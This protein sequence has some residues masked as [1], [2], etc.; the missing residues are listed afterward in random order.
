MALFLTESDVRS[1]LPMPVLIE[2]MA[3]ALAQYSKGGVVQP[4][5][6]V[7]QVQGPHA[8]MAA[9]PAAVADPPAL[10]AKLVTVYHGNHARGLPSHL[11]TIVLLDHATGALLAVMD[12]RYI[13][14]ART[15]AVSAVSVAH[16]AVPDA[17]V[18]AILGSGVQAR[19]HFEAIRTVRPL[20]DVRIWS[21]TAAHRDACASEL[22]KSSGLNVRAV[23]SAA[24]AVNGAQIIALTTASPTPVLDL[25]DVTPG[26]HIAAVGACTPK[27]RE[28][29]TALVREARVFADSRA[30]AIKEAGDL[31]LPMQEG[32]FDVSHIAG[33]LGEVVD[34]RVSGREHNRQITLFKS[35]GMAVE[36]VVAA[37]IA[38][39]QASKAGVG[40]VLKTT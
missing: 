12:G 25:A 21:P 1:L 9:M 4:V 36:D 11:A 40:Q 31:L 35:L 13:T 32:A 27:T 5:R 15:A 2:A 23:S 10:G 28:M 38:F 22:A 37:R 14:E 3:G 20:D 19:S 26:A 8:L 33:E 30:G 16:L 17:R 34:G 7:L 29:T 24:E 6:T 18:L 39:E